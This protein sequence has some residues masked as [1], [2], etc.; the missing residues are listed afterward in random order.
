MFNIMMVCIETQVSPQLL[1]STF[2]VTFACSQSASSIVSLICILPMPIPVLVTSGFSG[3]AFALSILLPKEYYQHLREVE[4]SAEM[5]EMGFVSIKAEN[6]TN[7]HDKD[8]MNPKVND[9]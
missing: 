8:E 6:L 3:L 9:F 2:Q 1:A 5:N 4:E 7:H